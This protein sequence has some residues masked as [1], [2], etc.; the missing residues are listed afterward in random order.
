MKNSGAPFLLHSNPSFPTKRFTKAYTLH[1]INICE[2]IAMAKTVNMC[3]RVD[4]ELK[5]Q[6]EIILE[7]LGMNMNG[8][9]N[10]FLNQ[11]VREKKVPLNLSLNKEQ[12]VLPDIVV[13]K[14]EREG[15][16]EGIDARKLLEEMKKLVSDAETRKE[17]SDSKAAG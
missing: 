6:A 4:P 8:T 2:V 16:I 9:I 3:V 11:I 5:A 10:M 13:S 1:I 17:N 7:Q 14:Q 15:G 12:D